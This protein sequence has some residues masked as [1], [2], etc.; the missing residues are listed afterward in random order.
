MAL[1]A[2]LQFMNQS[3]NHKIVYGHQLRFGPYNILW[4]T[5]RFINCHMALSAMNYLLTVIYFR[6]F[7]KCLSFCND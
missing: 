1:L 5:S 6:L 2:K 7:F 4:V 3:V